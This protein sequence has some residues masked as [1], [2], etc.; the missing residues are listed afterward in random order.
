MKKIYENLTPNTIH[1]INPR[2]VQK[3]VQLVALSQT[4]RYEW[5]NKHPINETNEDFRDSQGLRFT[6]LWPGFSNI[7]KMWKFSMNSNSTEGS[8]ESIFQRIWDMLLWDRIDEFN[9]NCVFSN[10]LKK[11]WWLSV[12]NCSKK[13]KLNRKSV[14]LS[15]IELLLYE[16]TTCRNMQ[17]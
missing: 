8:S 9:I 15:G 3:P 5:K 10:R 14:T 2:Q 11:I 17:K 7:L 13:G 6:N 12:L 16:A 4:K 1:K